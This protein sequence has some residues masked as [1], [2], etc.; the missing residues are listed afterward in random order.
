MENLTQIAD[1]LPQRNEKRPSGLSREESREEWK[2]GITLY[3]DK[4]A[5]PRLIAEEVVKLKSA[6][7]AISNE[8][9]D[10]LSERI[11]AN[12]FTEERIRD[13][14]VYVLDNFRYR[15][16]TIADVISFDKRVKV[17]SYAQI[18]RMLVEVGPSVWNDYKPVK[19]EGVDRTVY[20]N[21][22]EAESLG[23]KYKLVDIKTIEQ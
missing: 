21:I 12:N 18:L 22:A 19:I 14:V 6:F 2:N 8:F 16:P 17:Y 4:Q 15:Q 11:Y 23:L 1:L 3:N 20:V 9:L 10:V 13:A 7:P 5:E